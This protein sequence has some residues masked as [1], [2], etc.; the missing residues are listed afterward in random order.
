MQPLNQ[1][2]NFQPKQQNAQPA[3]NQNTA[4]K[5]KTTKEVK[6]IVEGNCRY[7]NILGQQTTVQLQADMPDLRESKAFGQDCR[8]RVP[9]ASAYRNVPYEKQSTT[10]NREFRKDFKQ[11]QNSRQPAYQVTQATDQ[12]IQTFMTWS[13]M[14]NSTRIQK[15]CKATSSST[16]PDYKCAQQ[17][18]D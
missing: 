9:G 12:P 11:S 18:T 2:F 16:K 6:R 5:T 10:E 3:S 8:N 17:T 4:D 1:H 7:C 13:T 15:T 14:T